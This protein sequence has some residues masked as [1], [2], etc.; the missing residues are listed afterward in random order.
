MLFFCNHHF[1]RSVRTWLPAVGTT[2]LLILKPLPAWALSPQEVFTR[3]APAVAALEVRDSAGRLLGV[4]SA[5][6]IGEQQFV[7]VC[8]VLEQAHTLQLTAPPAPARI[9][10]RDRER[11]LCLLEVEAP[12]APPLALQNQAP[13]V[14]S[15]VFAISNALGL[16]VG[17]S[18]GVVSGLRHFAGGDYI[19]F[20]A[21]I[22][23]GSEG[24]ALVD[25]QG[26]LLGIIDYRQR[27]GQNVNFASFA[28]WTQEITPRAAAQAEQLQRFDAANALLQQEKWLELEALSR[29]WRQEQPDNA[30]AWRFASAA[31][32]GLKNTAAELAAWRQRYRISPAQL[33]AGT[34]LGA[35]L[36]AQNL[37]KEALAHARQLLAQHQESAQAHLL[38]ARAQQATGARQE[39]EASY[40]QALTLNPWLIGA[41]QGLA[42]LAQARGDTA[43]AIG[44]WTRL[45]G[46]YPAAFEPRIQLVRAYLAA[47][48]AA[49][50]YSTLDKLPEADRDT[51]AA[52]YW[53]GVVLMRL[54]CP[55]AAVQAYRNS[56]ERQFSNPDW[57]WGG[58]G[59]AMADMKRYPE[60][61]RALESAR[62]ANP[63]NDTWT[64]QLGV[65]LKDGGRA[66][67]A[68][69]IAMALTEK[70]PESAWYW[71]LRGRTLGALAR[72]LE[73]IPAI[74]RS[75][76]LAPQQVSQWEA[77]VQLNQM[78]GRRPQAREAYQKL[79][80]L[81]AA[82]AETMYRGYIL[83]FEGE[84]P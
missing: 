45:S 50:A 62:Q 10:A 15:K 49:R 78:L 25:A 2:M 75:L 51:A 84:T 53:R 72:P 68:L 73:A 54:D 55:E 66:S 16:G 42:D 11:N 61:I 77:L 35:V 22:S 8:D 71:R 36:L 69:P 20:T 65:Y 41:Y 12:A 21:S 4:Y 39:A 38:L 59:E 28:T 26:Q 81:N 17:I 83:P 58:I 30:D 79:R 82:A 23:P 33:D 57:A 74:E 44:I 24:G 5:T 29:T 67:E 31:A 13:V 56:L 37:P 60:A 64:Y 18:E 43:T 80:A 3:A 7:A 48:Q 47:N 52:G 9:V 6:R 1:R 27:D 40:Q 34:G 46:L 19:Q 70:D 32:A 76:Q 14:G 63:D